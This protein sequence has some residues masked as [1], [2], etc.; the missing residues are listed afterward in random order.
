MRLLIISA[1]YPN[2]KDG[3][4]EYTQKYFNEALSKFKEVYLITSKDVKVDNKNILNDFKKWDLKAIVKVMKRIKE[5]K[6]DIIQLEYPSK[7]YGKR[8]AINFLPLLNK[9][10]LRKKILLR[11]HEF[12]NSR[13]LRKMCDIP[14]VLFSDMI[15]TP[16]KKDCDLLKK[17]YFF[18]KKKVSYVPIGV[19]IENYSE[20]INDEK[21]KNIL[22]IGYFGFPYEGKGLE[23]IIEA[24]EVFQ[25]KNRKFKMNFICEFNENNLYQKGIEDKIKSSLDVKNYCITGYEEAEKIS[26]LINNC[27]IFILPF[28]EG[29]TLRRGSFLTAAFHRK[30]IIT[31][32]SEEVKNIFID[33]EDIMYAES[34]EDVISKLEI[35]YRDKELRKRMGDN[36]FSKVQQFTW[37]AILEKMDKYYKKMIK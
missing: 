6:P 26:L 28:D 9:I 11:Y 13:M 4:S 16:A 30:S 37:P 18:R 1:S 31:T 10:F 20:K 27:D 21:E 36:I 19:N 32:I 5:L 24:C 15:I 25:K 22:D 23:K 12:S 14:L 34:V 8:I 7:G 29:L 17:I 3:M 33:N 35:L 2:I